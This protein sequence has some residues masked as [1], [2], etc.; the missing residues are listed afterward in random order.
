MTFIVSDL[1]QCPSLELKLMTT[2]LVLFT[3]VFTVP[4][5]L[6]GHRKKKKD[7]QK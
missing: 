5:T 2:V 4:G 1:F 3:T 7:R 6:L